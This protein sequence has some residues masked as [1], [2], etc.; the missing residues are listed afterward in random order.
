MAD[1]IGSVGQGMNWATTINQV[2]VWIFIIAVIALVSAALGWIGALIYRFFKYRINIYILEPTGA[3]SFK[4]ETDLGLQKD[5][6]GGEIEMFKRKKNIGVPSPEHFLPQG[7]KKSLFLTKV[8]DQ[9]IPVA[10]RHNSPANFNIDLDKLASAVKWQ[11]MY[12]EKKDQEYNLN[13]PSLWDKY[14]A[15]ISVGVLGVIFFVLFFVLIQKMQDGVT[16]RAVIEGAGQ[17][18]KPG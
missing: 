4:L 12:K 11:M 15:V 3:N 17:V 5:K 6:E 2:I 7:W 10:I 18:V 9:Y 8:N 14:G 1:L 16:V 13:K